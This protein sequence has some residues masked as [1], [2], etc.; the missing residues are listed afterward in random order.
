[1]DTETL[2]DFESLMDKKLA[3][4]IAKLDE[5]NHMLKAFTSN[6]KSGNSE[7]LYKDLSHIREMVEVIRNEINY[8]EK[9]TTS[10]SP[11]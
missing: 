10:R 4:I 2:K 1:M 11:S 9:I 5:T 6:E 7:S 8:S 3:P